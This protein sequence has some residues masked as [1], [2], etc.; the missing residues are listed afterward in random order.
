M[1]KQEQTRLV[2]L[3]SKLLQ[4]AAS[5]SR[6]VSHACRH[7]GV[8]RQLFYNTNGRKRYEEIG[9]DG[10]REESRRPRVSPRALPEAMVEL[11]VATRQAHPRWGRGRSARA[12][13]ASTRSSRCRGPAPSVK[14]S[15]ASA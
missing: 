10:L 5:T 1:T 12:C 15:S 2:R 14:C 7:Y 8:S 13:S 9:L 4:M 6:G 3:R 11:L